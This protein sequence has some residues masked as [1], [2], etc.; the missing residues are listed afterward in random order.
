MTSVLMTKF[1][2]LSLS[3]LKVLFFSLFL[4]FLLIGCKEAQ[5]PEI[6]IQ[7]KSKIAT[8]NSQATLLVSAQISDEGILSY[9]WY[10]N[11]KN[12]TDGGTAIEGANSDVFTFTVPSEGFAYYYV[13]IT[14]INA[15]LTSYANV[16]SDVAVI[17]VVDYDVFEVLFYD[18]NLKLLNV[19]TVKG[20]EEINPSKIYT[21]EDWYRLDSETAVDKLTI[22]TTTVLFAIAN[23]KS[24]KDRAGLEAIRNNLNG[25]YVLEA[26]I[27]LSDS[28]WTPIGT[29]E[30]PFTGVL[31]GLGKVYV[32]KGLTINKPSSDYIGLFGYVKGAHI[33]VI[34]LDLGSNGI[35]GNNYVGGIAGYISSSTITLV[36]VSGEYIKGNS[37]VGSIAGAAKASTIFYSGSSV[38]IEATGDYVGGIVGDA[39]F[40]TIAVISYTCNIKAAGDYVGGIAGFS[41]FST[42]AIAMVYGEIT[43]NKYVGSMAGRLRFGVIVA[44]TYFHRVVNGNS[45]VGWIAGDN[46]F[47]LI[48]YSYVS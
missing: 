2:I 7:P 48:I 31:I 41:D 22:D 8:A 20:G 32:I 42:I 17:E 43:G 15:N 12:S 4:G 16:T 27:D 6:I 44:S 35:V 33:A 13:V 26:D 9:Q 34:W 18:E 40:V 21:N 14:N 25:R 47:G 46:L 10:S 39:N 23:V 1:D 28:D 3:K 5:I 30:N 19:E 37:Y 38:N 11:T 45:K 29:K 36:A 24:I